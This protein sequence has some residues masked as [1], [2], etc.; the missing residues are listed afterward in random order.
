MRAVGKA[1]MMM[2]VRTSVGRLLA[3][4]PAITPSTQSGLSTRMPGVKCSSCTRTQCTLPYG[5]QRMH[6]Y[7]IHIW[8]H[9]AHTRMHGWWYKEHPT[10]AHNGGRAETRQQPLP[11]GPD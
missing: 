8:T 7:T 11:A 2:V 10:P 9:H 6:T 4:Q 5:G 3:Q 1:H